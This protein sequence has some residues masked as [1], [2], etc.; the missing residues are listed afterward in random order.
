MVSSK[1]IILPLFLVVF[2][3]FFINVQ[4]TRPNLLSS[5]FVLQNASLIGQDWELLIADLEF[6]QPLFLNVPHLCPHAEVPCPPL[7]FF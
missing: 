4:S 7:S 6:D 5:S 2:F 3:G 1:I